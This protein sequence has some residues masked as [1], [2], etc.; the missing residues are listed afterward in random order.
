VG[1]KFK[2]GAFEAIHGAVQG[3]HRAGT[4]SKETMREFDETCLTKPRV[5]RADE[6][7]A[8]RERNRVSQ[9][10]FARYLNTSESTIVQWERGDKNPSGI[11]LRLLELIEKHGVGIV[12]K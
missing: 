4:V 1:R 6:I 10:V 11:A 5:L 9:P 7:R 2:S 3:M 12:A 8:L